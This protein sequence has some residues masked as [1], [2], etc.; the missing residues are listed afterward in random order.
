[1]KVLS[2]IFFKKYI[3]YNSIEVI[4]LAT[5]KDVAKLA[6]VS[7]S[8]VSIVINGHAKERK[9]PNSTIDKVMQAVM[10]LNY[11]PN[12]N[13]RRLREN[14]HK[15][16]FALYW[17]LDSR[18]N[19]LASLLS[20]FQEIIHKNKIHC[21][22]IVK[23]YQTNHI[24]DS[25]Q[26]V[27]NNSF[28]AVIIGGTDA[29]DLQYL[30]NI[31]TNAPVLLINRDSNIHSTV[32]ISNETIIDMSIQLLSFH[33][34]Q[35]VHLIT[36]ASPFYAAK[37]RTNAFIEACQTKNIPITKQY[38]TL[39]SFEGGIE[40]A[41]KYKQ[42]QN[43]IIFCEDSPIALGMLY[44]MNR[45]QIHVPKDISIFSLNYSDLHYTCYATPSLT[46]IHVPYEKI[47]SCAV[48]TL[49]ELCKN[50]KK[51]LHETIQPELFIKES[52]TL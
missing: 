19:M 23:T 44:Y 30:E 40:I 42:I 21:E 39:N 48:N 9:I 18:T 3:C 34:N 17:P 38:T 33:R 4:L 41:K 49:F 5:I 50:K 36:S 46:T 28:D 43:C 10:E 29:Q 6:N 37:Q 15:L 11:R 16:I 45:H 22:I 51:I 7:V 8:T 52:C 12:V 35:E 47:A 1:M 25:F 20:G 13:A 24:Q 27:L 14:N 32:S 26:D 2:S 31:T